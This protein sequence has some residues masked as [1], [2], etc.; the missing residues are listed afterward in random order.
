M[1]R[2]F[3][4]R[5]R[6]PP[7]PTDTSTEEQSP[8]YSATWYFRGIRMTRPSFSP[9]ALGCVLYQLVSPNHMALFKTQRHTLN[10]AAWCTSNGRTHR[11]FSSFQNLKGNLGYLICGL[12]DPSPSS[13]YGFREVSSHQLFLNLC[14]TSEFFDA[15]SCALGSARIN[16][17]LKMWPRAS[18]S[19][20][21]L[22]SVGPPTLSKRR[23]VQA[24]MNSRVGTT[25]FVAMVSMHFNH[26]IPPRLP[27]SVTNMN[28]PFYDLRNN[29]YSL[30]LQLIH[31]PHS[32]SSHL[33]A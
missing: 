8:V 31:A 4:P 27:Y 18:Q 15:Y 20:A 9:G 26:L 25:R 17:R 6:T 22:G 10:Y 14:G 7:R 21:T 3:A 29:S 5:A 11:Q 16:A 19:L 32:T 13:R 30:L 23:S 1:T 28:M 12:L 33:S 24:G 2:H